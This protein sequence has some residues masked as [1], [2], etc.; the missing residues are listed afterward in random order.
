MRRPTR[1]LCVCVRASRAS[2]A[3]FAS[4]LSRFRS[5]GRARARLSGGR[6][7]VDG[8]RSTVDGRR[9]GDVR[10]RIRRCCAGC[11]A[12]AS[13]RV[14]DFLRTTAADKRIEVSKRI[15]EKYTDRIPVRRTARA[16]PRLGAGG[17][18]PPADG[19]APR[20]QVIVEKAPK[21]DVPDIDKKKYLVPSD[22]T[23]GKF[24]YEI[25][26]HMN[27]SPQ[28][29]IFLFVGN[30]VLPPTGSCS[31]FFRDARSTGAPRAQRP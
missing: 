28:K 15:R 9:A 10:R 27:L 14:G 16:E 13:G 6:S 11:R 22:I 30:G 26:K 17:P 4:P 25:R 3:C 7:T 31:A 1:A 8:R 12:V 2:L 19:R 29:A 5:G 21:S 20:G 18:P 24:V 23:V